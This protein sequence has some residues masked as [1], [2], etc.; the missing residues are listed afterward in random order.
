MVVEGPE[1]QPFWIVVVGDLIWLESQ[2]DVAHVWL[3]VCIR[4][5]VEQ[6]M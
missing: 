1:R 5:I 2:L 3:H 4:L 6:S